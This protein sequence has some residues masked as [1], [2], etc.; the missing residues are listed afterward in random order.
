MPVLLV[1]EMNPLLA[2]GFLVVWESVP[3]PYGAP[4]LTGRGFTETVLWMMTTES[5]L[6]APLLTPPGTETA[7][8]GVAVGAAV[9]VAVY[10]MLAGS[11]GFK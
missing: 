10:K 1:L 6:A 5:L 11:G 3:L 4:E 8:V 7:A 2:H 9:G